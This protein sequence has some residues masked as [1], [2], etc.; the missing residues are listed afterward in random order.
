MALKRSE[1]GLTVLTISGEHD[2]STAPELRRSLERLISG[3]DP[4]VIDL[5]PATFVD[6]SVLGVILDARR[7]AEE[8][9]LGFAVAHE[10]NGNDAVARVLEITGLR[11]ELPVHLI[12]DEAVSAASA[13]S[14]KKES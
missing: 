10:V 9:G 6:S 5:S 1:A 14:G 4:I 13:R 12:R 11:S 7:R 2:L 3:G 8:A